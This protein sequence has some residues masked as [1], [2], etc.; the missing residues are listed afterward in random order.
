MMNIFSECRV[1]TVSQNRLYVLILLDLLKQSQMDKA[2]LWNLL[3]R[4]TFNLEVVSVLK[5]IGASAHSVWRRRY[6]SSAQWS[7]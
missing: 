1:D 3:M 7:H 4:L 5:Q 6:T 2:R